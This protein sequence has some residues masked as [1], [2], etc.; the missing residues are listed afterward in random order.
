MSK[1]MNHDESERIRTAFRLYEIGE[2]GMRDAAA[3]AGLGIGEMMTE[4]NER[5][6]PSNYDGAELADDV[7][8]LR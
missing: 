8:A 3:F 2:F 6:I 7:E 5:D 1:R 4:A